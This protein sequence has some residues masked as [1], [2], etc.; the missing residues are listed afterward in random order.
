MSLAI[1]LHF[2]LPFCHSNLIHGVSTVEVLETHS[3]LLS[4]TT[5]SF[6]SILIL[7]HSSHSHNQCPGFDLIGLAPLMY[8]SAVIFGCPISTL[9]TAARIISLVM[10]LTQK[11]YGSSVPYLCYTMKLKLLGLMKKDIHDLVP[12]SIPKHAYHCRVLQSRQM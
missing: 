7:Y 4:F 12:N 2:C 8:G 9:N 6:L 11:S 3:I 10:V 5:L 1:R